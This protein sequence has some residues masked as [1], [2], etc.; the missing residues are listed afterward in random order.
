MKTKICVIAVLLAV[1]LINTHAQGTW[2][3]KANFPGG[4]GRYASTGFSIG[5]KGYLGTG[6]D[7]TLGHQR[8]LWEYDPITN[9]WT[10]KADIQGVARGAA[11]AF[12]INGKGYLG[13]GSNF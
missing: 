1:G 3:R 10:Q 5:G 6:Y 9:A 7:F 11:V 4:F 2:T 8:D 13:T 12:A